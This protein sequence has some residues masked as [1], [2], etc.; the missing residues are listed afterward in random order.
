MSLGM[1]TSPLNFLQYLW[2][3]IKR[4]VHCIQMPAHSHG[5]SCPDS[6]ARLILPKERRP[7]R[8]LTIGNYRLQQTTNPMGKDYVFR[9]SLMPRRSA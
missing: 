9:Q 5:F 4:S 6:E 8:V 1:N 7:S 3:Q 2:M